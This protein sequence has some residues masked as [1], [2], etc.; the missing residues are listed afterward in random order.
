MKTRNRWLMTGFVVLSLFA[1]GCAA[2]KPVVTV[3]EAAAKA[4]AEEE[5][6]RLKAE[7]E[8]KAKA[9]AEAKAREA[10]LKAEAE[11]AAKAKAEAEAAIQAARQLSAIYF[12]FDKYNIRDDQ[13]PILAGH[14][15]KLAKAG[16]VKLILEG[17]CDERGTVEYNLALGQRRADSVKNFLVRAGIDPERLNTIS[18][19]KERPVDPGHNEA[20]WAKNRRVEFVP[21]P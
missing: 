8:A 20:A 10:Q 19:G 3:D 5:A 6:A 21:A 17:H 14:G 1:L 7:A 2:S 12:D 18:Y 11:A 9:E 15:E 16:E 13:Q 4:K